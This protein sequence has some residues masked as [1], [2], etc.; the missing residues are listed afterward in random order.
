V[1]SWING[2]GFG[3]QKS[4]QYEV[5]TADASVTA[6]M[7]IGGETCSGDDGDPF[8]SLTIALKVASSGVSNPSTIHVVRAI[9]LTSTNFGSPTLPAAFTVPTPTV[10]NFACS[11]SSPTTPEATISPTQ[12]PVVT[13]A[14][15]PKSI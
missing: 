13:D 2:D 1:S 6:S 5:Q 10:G 8:N 9:Q 15:I 12:S 14:N 7:A 11:C 3:F 4:A